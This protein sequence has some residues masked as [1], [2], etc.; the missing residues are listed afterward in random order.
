MEAKYKPGDKVDINR[1]NE[2]LEVEVFGY[3]FRNNR[4]FY[5]MRSGAQFY[6]VEESDI[7]EKTDG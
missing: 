1:D 2:I 3:F 6:L 7:L 5:S 4:T